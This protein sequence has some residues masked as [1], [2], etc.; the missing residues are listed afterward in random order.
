[1]HL[2]SPHCI[3]LFAH[4][5]LNIA[6]DHPAQRQPAVAPRGDPA[7]VA[8][9][10]Q[11]AVTRDFGVGWIVAECADKELGKS[12]HDEMYLWRTLVCAGIV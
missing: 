2:L 1:M 11:E 4:D 7:D 8:S 10:Y 6:Q 5:S 3:H 12:K 9:P